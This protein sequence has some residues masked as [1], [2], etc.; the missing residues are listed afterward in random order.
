MKLLPLPQALAM[1]LVSPAWSPRQGLACFLLDTQ[2]DAGCDLGQQ[3]P[4][5]QLKTKLLPKR[6]RL[7]RARDWPGFL[8]PKNGGGCQQVGSGTFM[9]THQE[10]K[11]Q[12]DL[13]TACKSLK[14]ISIAWISQII[15]PQSTTDIKCIWPLGSCS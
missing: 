10:G 3:T 4:L 15:E 6:M 1:A 12:Y 14:Q 5:P 13:K 2:S 9:L 7:A 8:F 11:E